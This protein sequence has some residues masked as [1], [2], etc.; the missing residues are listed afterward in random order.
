MYRE[1]GK[2]SSLKKVVVVVKNTLAYY[3]GTSMAKE[4]VL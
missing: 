2:Y 3:I 1:G 4:K